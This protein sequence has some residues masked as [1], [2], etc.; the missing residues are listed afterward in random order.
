MNKSQK[1][2]VFISILLCIF[3]FITYRIRINE[4]YNISK[5]LNRLSS[6]M[7][8]RQ[9]L[10]S[11]VLFFIG[12]CGRIGKKSKLG[13]WSNIAVSYIL[14]AA[15]WGIGSISCLFI[16]V[17]YNLISIFWG[18]G[19][20]IF[21]LR[22]FLNGYLEQNIIF[23]IYD[24]I[25]FIG[26]AAFAS[27]GLMN[28]SYGTGDSQYLIQQWGKGIAIL[29]E[30][31][32]TQQTFLT[33]TGML[34]ATF[35][36]L[37]YF[38]GADNIYTIHHCF[39]I[40]FWI[41]YG[42]IIEETLFQNKNYDSNKRKMISIG[43]S[44]ITYTL[45]PIRLL[46]G[47]II[48]HT[49]SMI[50]IF[51]LCYYLKRMLESKEEALLEHKI[52]IHIIVIAIM[53]LR[54]DSPITICVIIGCFS[55]CYVNKC[56][57]LM[58]FLLSAFITFLLY[59]LKI[60]SILKNGLNGHF[61]NIETLLLMV[62]AFVIVGSFILLGD[63]LTRAISKEHLCKICYA[64]LFAFNLIMFI[65]FG[66][67]YLENMHTVLQNTVTVDWFWGGTLGIMAICL[68]YMVSKKQKQDVYLLLGICLL[69]VYIDLGV[70]R[71]INGLIAARLGPG[72]SINRAI[73][74]VLPVFCYDF[75]FKLFSAYGATEKMSVTLDSEMSED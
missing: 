30:I 63:R 48:S 28:I 40:C 55:I 51:I 23:F 75:Y 37:T 43:L 26:I 61:V 59:Y 44:I 54:V 33:S 10:A 52:F 11:Y 34:P 21:V 27:T 36:S 25:I 57:K 50:Y 53:L 31:N 49:Y 8:I 2:G 56:K 9:I 4:T 67:T 38:F 65:I 74:S 12:Y 46:S 16:G 47:W 62:A 70:L 18:L 7:Q 1:R 60:F 3:T 71:T 29:G 24:S 39:E 68:L 19:I 35:S 20:G 6:G 73:I 58:A 69:I 17:N 72:D 5:L 42:K 45:P 66:E 13:T 32:N 14:G 41:L 22:F 64:S 15:I